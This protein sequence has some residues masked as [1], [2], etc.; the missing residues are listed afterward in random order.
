[1]KNIDEKIL[2]DTARVVSDGL[3]RNYTKFYFRRQLEQKGYQVSFQVKRT[4]VWFTTPGGVKI[5]SE[6]LNP[7]TE[8][9]CSAEA[10]LKRLNIKD[11]SPKID[12]GAFCKRYRIHE[13]KG[14]IIYVL[15][16]ENECWYVGETDDFQKRLESHCRGSKDSSIFVK[17]NPVVAVA[18]VFTTDIKTEPEVQVYENA[19]TLFLMCAYGVS[20]VQGGMFCANNT[21]EITRLLR[22]QGFGVK[23]DQPF[24]LRDS[25]TNSESYSK[26]SAHISAMRDSMKFKSL[27]WN[28]EILPRTI[29]AKLN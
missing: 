24:R 7:Y 29:S 18:A 20:R 1:M 8:I 17:E 16:L 21:R 12:I 11:S 13:A 3:L 15:K 19:Y 27:Y 2:R 14:R 28:E 25:Q 4:E 23:Y 5:L 9:D 22:T 26:G 6:Q 10:I